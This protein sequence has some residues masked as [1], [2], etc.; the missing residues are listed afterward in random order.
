MI[1]KPTA[2]DIIIQSSTVELLQCYDLAVAPR[3]RKEIRGYVPD[4]DVVGVIAFEGPKI[5][6]NLTLSIPVNVYNLPSVQR[7]KSTTRADWTRELTNQIMGRI[8]NRL[9]QFQVKLRTH[10]PAVLS[11]AAL[12]RHRLRTETAVLYS[13][14]ALRGE[15]SVTVDASLTRAVLEYSNSSM[16]VGEGELVLFE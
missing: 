11:G 2:V 15:I 8:K 3:G 10:V 12:E 9:L 1:L 14:G 6:G 4:S 16:L 7:S 5:V 13:F